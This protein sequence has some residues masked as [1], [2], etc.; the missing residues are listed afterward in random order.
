YNATATVSITEPSQLTAT[1][2]VISN[3][4]CFGGSNGSVQVT[5]SGGTSPY[6][7][8]WSNGML[9][10]VNSG[11]TAGTGGTTY[12]VT[13]TDN[14]GCITTATVSIIEPTQVTT[15]TLVLSNVSC[16]GGSNGSVQVTAGGGT[17]PYTYSWSNG[18]LTSV[19]SG[20]TAGTGGT[21]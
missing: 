3:V 5:T 13:V 9:S 8:L 18:A 10:S 21:T 11:L 7:Y 12:T 17:S 16:F 14:Q 15:T 19:N 4:K 6:T 2:S 1:P 20:L